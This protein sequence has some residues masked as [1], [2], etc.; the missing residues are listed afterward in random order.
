MMEVEERNNLQSE[1]MGDP[2]LYV[3]N[4][5]LHSERQED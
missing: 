1:W 5:D 2:K 4:Q 3:S